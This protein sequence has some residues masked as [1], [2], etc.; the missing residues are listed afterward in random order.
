[1]M[2]KKVLECTWLGILILYMNRQMIRN[3]A[4]TLLV[5]VERIEIV[6]DVN[7]DIEI[8]AKTVF[9]TLGIAAR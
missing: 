5:A 3:L 6:D 4:V 2:L 9:Q 1:M 8:S 7:V